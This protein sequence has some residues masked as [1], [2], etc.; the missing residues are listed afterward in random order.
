MKALIDPNGL[1]AQIEVEEFEMAPPCFWVDCP[2]NIVAG[3]YTY[4]NNQ[5]VPVVIPPPTLEEN[6]QLAKK[7][8]VESDWAILSDVNLANRVEWETYRAVIR[9]I[10]ISPQEGNIEWP[11]K[12]Q[13]IWS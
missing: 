8:L 5:F 10:A 12:P 7:L 3:Q 1:V 2:D 9:L 4:I 6:E 13:K 11:K